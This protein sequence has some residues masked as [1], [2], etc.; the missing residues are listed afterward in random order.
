MDI[1]RS[2]RINMAAR[3]YILSHITENLRQLETGTKGALV[4]DKY[5]I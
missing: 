2:E 3:V 1:C 5:R 4:Q